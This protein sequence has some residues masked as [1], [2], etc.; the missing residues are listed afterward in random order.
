MNSLQKILRVKSVGL[1][2]C[3]PHNV[4][5]EPVS[6]TLAAVM[7]FGAEVCKCCSKNDAHRHLWG[8]RAQAAARP[9]GEQGCP[10]S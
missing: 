10:A 2:H 1:L 9:Q 5:A 6:S 4:S 3:G 8:P 7:N